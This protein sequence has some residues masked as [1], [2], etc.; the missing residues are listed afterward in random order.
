M[1]ELKLVSA[2]HVLEQLDGATIVSSFVEDDEGLHLVMKDGRMLV[3]AGTFAI[4]IVHP[5]DRVLN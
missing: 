2:E 4:G 5:D 3:I 1:E